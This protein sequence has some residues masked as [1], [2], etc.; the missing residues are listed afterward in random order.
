MHG[1]SMKSGGE[2]NM[3]ATYACIIRLIKQRSTTH[4]LNNNNDSSFVEIQ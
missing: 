3:K 4:L 2:Y 1:I